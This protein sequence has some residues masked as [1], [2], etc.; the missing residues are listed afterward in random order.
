MINRLGN[1]LYWAVSTI[2]VVSLIFGG[3][4]A[5][6]MNNAS[7]SERLGFVIFAAVFALLS[8]L[9]GRAL[10]YVLAGR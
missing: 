9:I 1:V 10:L 8:W 4:I 5:I 7:W 6:F 3:V 2:A